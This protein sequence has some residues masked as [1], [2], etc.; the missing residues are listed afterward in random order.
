MS[1]PFQKNLGRPVLANSIGG[2][3]VMRAGLKMPCP[4]F[5][6]YINL[7]I[8]KRSSIVGRFRGLFYEF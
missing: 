4:F 1:A 2:E 3:P 8:A 5:I 7:W 6:A